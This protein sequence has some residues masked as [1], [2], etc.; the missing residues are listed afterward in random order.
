MNY[1][2]FP[3]DEAA[4]NVVDVWRFYYINTLTHELGDTNAY[5]LQPSLSVREVVDGHCCHTAYISVSELKK[6]KTKFLR[7]TGYLNSIKTY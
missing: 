1:V 6:I 5:K 4:N 2:L 7:C 3:A